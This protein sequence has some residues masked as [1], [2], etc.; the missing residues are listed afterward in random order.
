MKASLWGGG[1][2]TGGARGDITYPEKSPNPF[3]AI[4]V[5]DASRHGGVLRTTV[6]HVPRLNHINYEGTSNAHKH[7]PLRRKEERGDTN[8]QTWTREGNSYQDSRRWW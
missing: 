8:R 3:P 1:G 2:V 6:T 5:D 4:G 7:R